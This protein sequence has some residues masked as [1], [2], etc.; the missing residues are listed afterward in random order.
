[1]SK[2]LKN[3]FNSITP[4]NI[5]KIP[6]IRDAMDLFVETLEERAKESIE[7]GSIYENENIRKYMV[8]TY[9]NDL[10]NV[11]N[12]VQS[13]RQVNDAIDK[14]NSNYSITNSAGEPVEYI[15]KDAIENISSYITEDHFFT[16]RSY[17]Q[18]KGTLEALKYIYGLVN[19]FV[20]SEKNPAPLE[21]EEGDPF[22]LDIKGPL[23]VEFYEYIIY[24]LAHPLGFTYEYF[25]F[26]KEGLVDYFPELSIQYNTAILE[27]RCV[28]TDGSTSISPF[29]GPSVNTDLE[30]I[31]IVDTQIFGVK[32]RIVFLDDGTYLKQVTDE[33]NQTTVA[34]K[35]GTPENY[36]TDENNQDPDADPGNT[37]SNQCSIFID[38]TTTINTAVYDTKVT[39]QQETRLPLLIMDEPWHLINTFDIGQEYVGGIRDL[40]FD[41]S[42]DLDSD[43]ISF[44]IFRGTTE[45][46]D[47]NISA[48]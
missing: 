43:N 5:K 8:Q 47:D 40:Y 6:A 26:L 18:H 1:M 27:V 3:I 25:R 44:G 2:D 19:S 48:L 15:R 41:P 4:S 33:Q 23:P 35:I 34:H 20:L 16:F 7:I 13:N 22:H 11:L 28:N 24:P 30:V 31:D 21:I 45:L 14:I 32:T 46:T 17:K 29:I 37:F 12:S 10:Y 9:L 39:S 36:S 38:Y 42:F